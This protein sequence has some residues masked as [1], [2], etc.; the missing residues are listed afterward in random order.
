MDITL[1]M[2]WQQGA[3]AT[4]SSSGSAH[5]QIVRDL[6][7]LQGNFQERIL[8]QNNRMFAQHDEFVRTMLERINN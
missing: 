7:A 8:E 1:G 2:L 4:V 5:N 6:I 3:P